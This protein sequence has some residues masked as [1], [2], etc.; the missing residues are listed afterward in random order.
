MSRS[1]HLPTRILKVYIGTLTGFSH[2]YWPKYLNNTSLS[3]DCVLRGASSAGKSSRMHITRTEEGVGSLW[4]PGFSSRVNWQ[5]RVLDDSLQHPYALEKNMYSA[6]IG[7]MFYMYLLV[8]SI[9]DWQLD[10]D[11]SWSSW[12][13]M[14]AVKLPSY[15]YEGWVGCGVTEMWASHG[16]KT[17]GSWGSYWD[18]IDVSW[19]DALH[20]L[21][22]LRRISRD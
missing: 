9:L 13:H 21:C 18:L 4:L 3:P 22:A 17:S 5:S 14:A 10:R 20:L 12:L 6:F 16:S 15:W 7:W 19:I 11:W 1:L 8:L 2:V